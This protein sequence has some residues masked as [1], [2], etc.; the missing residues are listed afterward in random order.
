MPL[1][2]EEYIIGLAEYN[3]YVYGYFCACSEV[4]DN[5]ITCVV[6]FSK[7]NSFS[8]CNFKAGILFVMGSVPDIVYW[9]IL[10]Q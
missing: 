4:N 7:L 8:I 2:Y 3:K 1:N 6:A 10:L 5:I 9:T